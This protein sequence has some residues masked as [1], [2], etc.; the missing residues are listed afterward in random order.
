MKKERVPK[1]EVFQAIREQGIKKTEEVE[2]V[3]LEIDGTISVLSKEK[4]KWII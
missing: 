3:V 2:A 4:M 1:S